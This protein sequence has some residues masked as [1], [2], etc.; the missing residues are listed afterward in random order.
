MVAPHKEPEFKELMTKFNIPFDVYVPDVQ[1]LIDSE[2][3]PAQPLAAFDLNKYHTLDEIYAHLD[4]LAKS[5]P[6]K[7]QVIVG[8]KTY[9]GRQ[10]KG[11]KVSFGGN[12][13]GIFIEGGIHAREWI[14]PASILYM[15]NELLNSKSPDVRSLAE[16][17]EWYI[18]PV[19]NP[20]G[21]VYTHT[22]V[23]YLKRI[24]KLLVEKFDEFL[25]IFLNLRTAYG[26][27][28]ANHTVFCATDRTLTGTGVTNG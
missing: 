3:P 28:P 13:P 2:M 22:T 11:V 27:R 6:G 16:S 5:H 20:D 19:F 7:V 17:H 12:K 4:S 18:F 15:L 1:T 23:G 24:K 14:T 21:Y 25:I 8:G 26:E 9:E 10:I